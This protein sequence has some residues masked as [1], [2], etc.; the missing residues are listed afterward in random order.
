MRRIILSIIVFAV[1]VPFGVTCFYTVDRTE[2]VYL[3]EFGKHVRTLDGRNDE[4]A[5]LHFKWPF[6]IQS[7]QRLD[8][9]LQYLDVPGAEVMTR[10]EE[11]NTIDRTL[12][13][14]AYVCWRIPNARAVD[15][16]VR[17][18]GTTDGA[19][20]FLTRRLGSELG[21]LVAQMR[22]NDL[23]STDPGK[24]GRR[25]DEKRDELRSR[26]LK[27]VD[28][29]EQEYGIE[30]IDVRLRRTNHPESVRKSIYERIISEREKLATFY[31]S[32]GERMAGD[33]TSASNKRI[34]RLKSHADSEALK[35]RG[36][37][38]ANA[39]KIRSDAQK[40]DPA[41]Y[42]FLKKLDAYK[43]ILGDNKSLLLLS[44]DRKIF[45]LFNDPPEMKK[46]KD[47]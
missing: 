25:V 8:R 16:F 44:T 28:Q 38:D 39:D 35:M 31:K 47:K 29:A 45:D 13:I 1:A 36:K 23:V 3:T 37:A 14:D 43:R 27:Q 17:T 22:M 11:R 10:D 32:E 6:P 20:D 5:G 9:R 34:A 12:T 40:Q 46:D 21:A 24:V 7:V 33:I 26:L 4:E 2:Y 15:Q 18:V 30:V 42:A 19:K 41:F